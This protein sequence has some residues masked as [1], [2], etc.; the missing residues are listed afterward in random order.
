MSSDSLDMSCIDCHKTEKH[1]ISGKLYSVSAAN[2]NRATCEE[3][4]SS[5]PHMDKILDDHYYKVACQTCHIPAYA[6]ANGTKL[7]WDWSAAG[8]L[9]DMGLPIHEPDADGNHKYLSIK[10]NFVWNDDV[11]PEY[12]WFNGTA[13]HYLSSDTIKEIPV[14]INTLFGDYKDRDAKIWPVKVHRGKQIYDTVHNQ[15]IH[16]KLWA[17]EQGEGAYW[18]D[19]DWDKAAQLG[20]EYNERPYSG[21]YGFIE[22]E[23]YWPV[24]HMVAPKE[25]T[26]SCSECHSRDGRLAGVDDF[27]LP[28]RDY[29][30]I[31]EYGGIIL[32]ILSIVAT[33]GHGIIRIFSSS[34]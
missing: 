10:G 20:M 31:V 24:N 4:H 2:T 9:S 21:H 18:K 16:L 27:Y 7:Y 3:C 28:G 6:K 34:N 17:Q 11:A 19:F 30:A 29:S 22:S 32:I 33:L 23:A 25:E 8:R 5:Q 1:N 12:Y 15:L 14:K 13:D 26:L